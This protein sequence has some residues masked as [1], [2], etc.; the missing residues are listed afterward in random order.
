MPWQRTSGHREEER[1][2]EGEA[3]EGEDDWIPVRWPEEEDKSKEGRL[4]KT[5]AAMDGWMHWRRNLTAKGRRKRGLLRE[6]FWYTEI[7][8]MVDAVS[9]SSSRRSHARCTGRAAAGQRCSGRLVHGRAGTPAQAQQAQ[10]VG[11]GRVQGASAAQA[12]EASPG[13]SASSYIDSS[14]VSSF[15]PF[16]HIYLFP[17][18]VL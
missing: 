10:H 12:A 11:A 14:T 18:T 16:S 2:P 9:S 15:L 17:T 1:Q 4:E 8:N 5:S 3:A 13:S 7:E 6:E